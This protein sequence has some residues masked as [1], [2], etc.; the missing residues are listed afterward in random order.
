MNDNNEQGREACGRS[1]SAGY[2]ADVL[3]VGNEYEIGDSVYLRTDTDQKERIVTAIMIRPG[4][5]A[6]ELTCGTEGS[7]H[8]AFEIT[9]ERDVLKAT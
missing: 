8:Y 5:M 4:R 3:L 9:K 6:Y 2:V 1:A 7:W